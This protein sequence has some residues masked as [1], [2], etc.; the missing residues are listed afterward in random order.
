[1]LFFFFFL[2]LNRQKLIE[3]ISHGAEIWDEETGAS[4]HEINKQINKKRERETV[5]QKQISGRDY[6]TVGA[7]RFKPES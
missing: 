6:S 4:L 7:H 5:V 2:F 3:L 1:M